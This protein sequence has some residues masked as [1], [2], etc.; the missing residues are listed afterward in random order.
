MLLP[1]ELPQKPKARII[2]LFFKITFM[3]Y[4]FIA[5]FYAYNKRYNLILRR[6]SICMSQSNQPS[7]LKLP[8]EELPS[9]TLDEQQIQDLRSILNRSMESLEDGNITE[10]IT[11]LRR[12]DDQLRILED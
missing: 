8:L 12:A 4:H 3:I 10:A 1:E 6:I 11:N 5:L 7:N 2:H 9:A